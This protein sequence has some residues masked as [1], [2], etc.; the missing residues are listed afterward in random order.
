[1]SE[2]IKDGEF[3]CP[4]LKGEIEKAGSGEDTGIEGKHW[5]K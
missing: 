2:T 3:G 1:M 4:W 5:S